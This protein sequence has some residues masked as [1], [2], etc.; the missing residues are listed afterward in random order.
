MLTFDRTHTTYV[1]IVPPI[2]VLNVPPKVG[3][4]KELV[5]SAVDSTD[6]SND[7]NGISYVWKCHNVSYFYIQSSYSSSTAY[8]TMSYE[9]FEDALI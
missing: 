2:A 4:A 9:N 5:L 1:T 3:T 7:I 8:H 6:P